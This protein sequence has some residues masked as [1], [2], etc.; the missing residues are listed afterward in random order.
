[1]KNGPMLAALL[2]VAVS[3]CGT[4]V[5]IPPRIDL[6][7]YQ[8]VGVLEFTT[9]SE[10]ELGPF[11]TRR[12]MELARQDQG[13]VRM[14]DLG[15]VAQALEAVERPRL[16]PAAIKALG[17]RHDVR[18]LITGT[19][20][21]S[22]VR[23]VIQITPGIVSSGIAADVDATLA[24]QMVEAETGASLWSSSARATRRVGHVRIL[25]GREF[26]FDAANP[27]RA[28][29][30]LVEALVFQVTRDFRVSWVRQ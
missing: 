17:A 7:E 22:D 26:A 24:V 18:T 13:I 30:D 5:M 19:L 2:V 16:D 29:A 23:P 6:T 28:Y 4:R 21:V 1:M 10:G 9:A 15:S 25:G 8:V 11:V 20:E 14:A 27:D 3:A 12:F